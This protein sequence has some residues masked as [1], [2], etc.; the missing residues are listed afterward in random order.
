[1]PYGDDMVGTFD[2]GFKADHGHTHLLQHLWDAYSAHLVAEIATRRSN[3]YRAVDIDEAKRR[4]PATAFLKW[5]AT[6]LKDNPV[7]ESFFIDGNSG[8]RLSNGSRL[9][10]CPG[11]VERGSMQSS[12]AVAVTQGLSQVGAPANKPDDTMRI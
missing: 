9:A 6:Y 4:V 8:V 2:D 11:G 10:V 3:G 12:E 1:M 7:V 5:A